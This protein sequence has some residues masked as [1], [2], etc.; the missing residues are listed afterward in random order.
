MSWQLN[1]AS[2]KTKSTPFVSGICLSFIDWAYTR[3][4]WCASPEW[5]VSWNIGK[6]WAH[7][8]EEMEHDWSS[9]RK[10]LCLSLPEKENS[11]VDGLSHDGFLSTTT[12]FL[13]EPVKSHAIVPENFSFCRLR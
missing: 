5:S 13:L 3:F 1:T 7:P 10:N 2:P 11:R 12:T 9:R 8:A 4:C 6:R